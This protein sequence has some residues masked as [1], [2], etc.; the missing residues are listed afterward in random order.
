MPAT[1]TIS[2][3]RADSE[4]PVKRATSRSS[5]SRTEPD[6]VAAV[7]LRREG[8]LEAAADDQPEQLVVGDRLDAADAAHLAVAQDRDAVGDDAHLGEPVGDVDDRRPALGDATDVAEQQVHR[9]LVERCGRLVEDQHGGLDRERLGELEEVLVDDRQRVDAVVEVRLE[10][11]LVEDPADRH[12]AR[13]RPAGETTWGRATRTFS[14]TVMSG[15]SAGCWW[16]MA[17]PSCAADVGV[18]RSTARRRPRSCRCRGR[19]CRRRRS[20]A[21][22]C[23]RRSRRAGRA[24][25]PAAPRGRRR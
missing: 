2:P 20:S 25:R 23:R 16:T 3:G 6:V 4:M 12:P 19:S 21:S 5:I 8:R 1:P 18:R 11:D 7:R 24:P 10:A 22:T 14:A 9:L 13:G 17:M 15:S